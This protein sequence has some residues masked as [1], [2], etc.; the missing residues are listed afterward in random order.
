[1]PWMRIMSLILQG[2]ISC[3]SGTNASTETVLIPCWRA[4][5]ASVGGFV[6]CE[7]KSAIDNR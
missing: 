3:R 7:L 6:F 1:M 5:L 4:I 2:M